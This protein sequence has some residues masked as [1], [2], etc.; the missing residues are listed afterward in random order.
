M[1]LTIGLRLWL[2]FALFLAPLSLLTYLFWT[3]ARSDIAFVEK[4]IQ[5]AQYLSE[6][7]PQFVQSAQ[8]GANAP[9]LPHAT[10][11]DALFGTQDASSAFTKAA[12]PQSRASTGKTL[13]GAVADGSNL[14]LN[15]DL[16]SFYVMYAVTVRMPGVVQA[17]VEL[18]DAVHAVDTPQKVVSI[19]YAVQQL[20][21]FASATD[22][23]L[24]AS[25]KNNASGET[26][27]ALETHAKDLRAAAT[28]VLNQSHLLLDGVPTDELDARISDLIGRT[29][30]TWSASNA[31]LSRL[32]QARE[33]D[34]VCPHL[35]EPQCQPGALEAGIA[36]HQDAPAGERLCQ[37]VHHVFHGA[38][39]AS[40]NSFSSL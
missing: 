22:I 25:M 7:W 9:S 30:Q 6:I 28:K 16:D 32:L 19:A 38:L 35:R 23:S 8:P 12:D 21:Y 34:H 15:P 10:E 36:G 24:N 20:K 40:H 1:K 14:T 27:L 26:R 11:F 3:Q 18:R 13:M 4:E 2:I 29:D 17:A 5:G 33:A 37:G 39:P 31:E